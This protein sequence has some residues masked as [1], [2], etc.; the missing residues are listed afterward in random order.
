MS[1]TITAEITRSIERIFDMGGRTLAEKIIIYPCGDVGIQTVNILKDIYSIEPAYLI[2]NHK[3][4]YSEKI[5]DISILKSINIDEYVLFL[6][7]T[8]LDIYM[9]LKN[10]VL[11]YFQEEKIIELEQ[12]E[13]LSNFY[14]KTEI[15]KHSYGSLCRP[16]V[17]IKSIGAFCSFAQGVECVVN[18]EMNYVTTHP[19][20]YQGKYF[21]EK[22]YPNELF[23]HEA[24]YF[25]GID[26]K[27]EKIKKQKKITIG[28]DVWLGQNVIIT[29]SS[30]IG[31]GVVAAAGAVITKDV[32]DYAVVA[33]VP[34]R[35]IKY[36]YT[37]E[38]IK[39]LNKIAWWDWSDDEIRERYEDFYLPIEEFI[40]KYK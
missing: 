38:Q 28:N 39:A 18:H 40:K 5:H 29:N 4:K 7:S 33:G 13:L 31:N 15:G 32:P 23:I 37:E 1:K 6:T 25:P 11:E 21:E 19:M 24:Y 17:M 27:S 34:A 16:H 36:R 22:D 35:I 12:M 2:D 20:I 14:I 3:C 26:P 10:R 9:E 8:N 30:N